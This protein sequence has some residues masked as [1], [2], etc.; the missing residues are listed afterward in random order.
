MKQEIMREITPLTQS[1]CFTLL[2]RV[3]EKFDFPL[4]YH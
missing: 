4:H 3:K 1:D 2:S